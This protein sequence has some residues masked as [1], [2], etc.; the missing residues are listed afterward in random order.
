LRL[1]TKINPVE[2]GQLGNHDE[3]QRLD[4]KLIGLGPTLDFLR[5]FRDRRP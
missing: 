4:I 2:P 1:R 5:Q 3:A